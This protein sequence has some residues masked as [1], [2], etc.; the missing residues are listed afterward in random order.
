MKVPKMFKPDIKERR[1]EKKIL[2]R[3]YIDSER[4]FLL[5]LY[6]PGPGGRYTRSAELSDEERGRLWPDRS[7]RTEGWCAPESSP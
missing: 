3:V 7:G 6:S 5:R 1:F 4:A 2:R